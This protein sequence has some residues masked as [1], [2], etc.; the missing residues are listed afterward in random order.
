MHLEKGEGKRG[1]TYCS[2]AMSFFAQFLLHGVS[3][4]LWRRGS[5]IDSPRIDDL[6]VPLLQKKAD[7]RVH[8]RENASSPCRCFGRLIQS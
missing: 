6:E 3:E 1:C 2:L 7:S 8:T 5:R 4:A